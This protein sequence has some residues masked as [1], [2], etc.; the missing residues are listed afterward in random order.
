MK[1]YPIKIP[2]KDFYFID[3]IS[4]AKGSRIKKVIIDKKGNKAFFKYQDVGYKSSEACSEKM[5][6]EIAKILNYECARI[7]L[8][9]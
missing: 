9:N 5:C 6:Y 4:N 2:S 3:N 7:E 1:K 8:G